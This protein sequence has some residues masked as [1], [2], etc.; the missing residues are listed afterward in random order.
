M[1]SNFIFNRRPAFAKKLWHG[2]QECPRYPLFE[3]ALTIFKLQK[4]MLQPKFS[5]V[6]TYHGFDSTGSM[7]YAGMAFQLDETACKNHLPALEY[8]KQGDAP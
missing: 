4:V 8:E 6:K 1:D 5:K 7:S 2:T 3:Q